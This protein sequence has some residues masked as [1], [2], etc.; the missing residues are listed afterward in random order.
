M[1]K[2]FMLIILENSP[3]KL[4]EYNSVKIFVYPS[5]NIYQIIVDI[6]IQNFV[7]GNHWDCYHFLIGR[8]LAKILHAFMSIIG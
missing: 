1:I 6:H 2:Y 7:Y 3:A 4:Q 8:Y 5:P